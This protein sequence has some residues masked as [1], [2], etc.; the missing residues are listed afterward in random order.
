MR[1][2]KP[3]IRPLVLSV[4]LIFLLTAGVCSFLMIG[5]DSSPKLARTNVVKIRPG[6]SLKEVQAIVGAPPNL[7]AK[8]PDTTTGI[9]RWAPR[10]VNWITA[11][12]ATTRSLRSFSTGKEE[13]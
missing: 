7:S 3:T 2:R 5:Q 1:F 10:Q 6:M 9:A 13:S 11:G 12:L 8:G 4:G